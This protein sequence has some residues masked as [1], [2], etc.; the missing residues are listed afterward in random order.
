[1][2]SNYIHNL[3]NIKLTTSY[4]NIEKH[5]HTYIYNTLKYKKKL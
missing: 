2:F 4:D 1:M 3:I 5:T